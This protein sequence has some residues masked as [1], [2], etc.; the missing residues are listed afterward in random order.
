MF[1]PKHAVPDCEYL[2]E[3]ATAESELAE[4]AGTGKPAD[5]H[6]QLASAYLSKVF[7]NEPDQVSRSNVTDRQEKH[8]AIRSVIAMMAE[9]ALPVP[10]SNKPELSHLLSC[11]S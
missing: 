9:V 7:D 10:R 2:L 6:R 3:R 11:L 8:E 1:F 4:R 5:L